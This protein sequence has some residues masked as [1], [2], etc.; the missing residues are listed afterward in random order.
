MKHIEKQVCESITAVVFH[1]GDEELVEE[2]TFHGKDKDPK[3][4]RAETK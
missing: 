4:V 3:F 1:G 2:V